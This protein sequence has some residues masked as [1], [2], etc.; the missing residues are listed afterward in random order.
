MRNYVGFLQ[1]GSHLSV[2][3]ESKKI[4]TA[5]I[6]ITTLLIFIII[7]KYSTQTYKQA[8]DHVHLTVLGANLQFSITAMALLHLGPVILDRLFT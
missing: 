1:I 3:T 5:D 8:L 4:Y 6:A 7:Y 2:I